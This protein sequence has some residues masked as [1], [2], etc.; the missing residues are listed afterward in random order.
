[1]IR[2][3]AA[4]WFSDETIRLAMTFSKRFCTAPK[5]ARWLLISSIAVKAGDTI[6]PGQQLFVIEAMKMEHALK[7]PRDG[8]VA[9]IAVNAGDQARM[10][11]VLVALEPAK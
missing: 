6:Q 11:D 1:M 7:A 3:R 9:R 10:R 2:L 8:V 5:V 4:A